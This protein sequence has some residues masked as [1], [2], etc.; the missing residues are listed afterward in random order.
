[1]SPDIKAVESLSLNS[2]ITLDLVKKWSRSFFKTLFDFSF[3]E[4][5]TVQMLP[6][7]YGLSIV[8]SAV[9]NA[10]LVFEAWLLSPWRGLLF[11]FI[12]CPV[13]FI[14]SIAVVRTCLEFFSAV[15]RLLSYMGHMSS[16]IDALGGR[17]EGLN[18]NITKVN[19]QIHNM[20][21]HI[22]NI[23]NHMSDISFIA[24]ELD[25]IADRIPFLKK[26]LRKSNQDSKQTE[27]TTED[28]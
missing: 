5:I 27:A 12:I 23:N 18:Q 22:Q 19:D 9:L 4:I 26:T 16:S 17:I 24:K 2:R 1:M 10:Y 6:L 11:L 28:S 21:T 3:S 15:F 14:F 7:L 8:A 13:L 20:D 25:D